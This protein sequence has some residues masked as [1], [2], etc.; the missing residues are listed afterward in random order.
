MLR[1]PHL[2]RV[3]RAVFGWAALLAAIA[4]AAEPVPFA[5]TDAV[6]GDWSDATKWTSADSSAPVAT[7]LA[8]YELDFSPAG[9]Y[10]ANQDL[11]AGF[12]LNRL[13]F[14]GSTVTLS[15]NALQFVTNGASLP[16]IRQN[17]DAEV[18]LD[19]PLGLGVDLSFGGT[20]TATV[21]LNGALTGNGGL[22]K[23]GPALLSLTAANSY[24]G[25]TT[26]TEGILRLA[27]PNTGND[28]SVVSIA[29]GAALDLT[30]TGSD[31][32]ASLLLAGVS[33]PDGLYDAANSGGAITG[34]GSLLVV[35]PP[36]WSDARL[37]SLAISG[38]SLSPSFSPL[39]GSYS[40]SVPNTVSTITVTPTVSG[41]G[42]TVTVN[43]NSV[44]PGAASNPIALGVGPNLITTQV[45][46]FDG[47]TT[48]TYTVNVSRGSAAVVGTSPA[49]VID[50]SRATLN[51]TTT[52]HGAA[53]VYFE[54]GPTA[55]FGS[56][57]P[58]RDVSGAGG[59]AAGVSGLS[60]ATTYHFRSVLVNPA[61][62]IYGETRQFTT[63]PN[64][65]VAA[66]GAPA[67]VTASTATLVGAVNPNGVQ[68]SVYFEYGLTT[69]YGQSTPVQKI[70]AGFATVGV[71]A[72]NLS[73]IA[74]GAYHYRLVASNSAGTALGNDV[75][76]S[77]TVGGGSG[78]GAPTAPPVVTT[79]DAAGIST[80]TA[81]LRGTVNPN[82]GTTLVKFEYGL[83]DSLGTATTLQG[84]GN[85]DDAADVAIPVQG[86][87]PGSTYHY[88]VSASNGLGTTPGDILTF[89]TDS[90]PPT[91]V[92]G[93]S[94][95]LTTTSVRIDGSARARGALA[96]VWIDYGTDGVSFDSV[97]ATPVS[98]SGDQ[99]TPVSAEVDEL[100]QGVTYYYRVRAV[101]PGGEGVGEI[102]TFNV[103]SLS[104]L[105]Q[106]YPPA[107]PLADRRGTVA[108]TLSP[109]DIGSGWR[110][111]GEQFWRES[112][113][114][115]TG[116]TAGD[117]V[118]EYRPV[119]GYVQPATEA[120]AVASSVTPLALT[121][122]YTPA[123]VTV[124]GSLTVILKPQDLTEGE[125]PAR[126]RFFGEE[127]AD[128]RESGVTVSDLAPGSYVIH[129][130]PIAGRA[131]PAPVTA[132]VDE[133][134]TTTL[135]I[136]YFIAEDPIGT[137]ATMVPFETFSTDTALPNA[138]VGQ[139]RSDAGLGSGFVVRPRV[140][141]TVGHAVFNDGTLSIATGLQWLFQHDRGV[142]DPVPKVPRGHYLM[143]GY[144]AQRVLDN[145]PGV[146]SPASQNLDVATMF[147]LEEVGR[148]GFS[149][150]LASDNL[151]NGFLL[152]NSL[153]TLVGYPIDGIAEADLDRL[154][155]TPATDVAFAPAFGRTF[156]TS[157]IRASGGASGGPVCVLSENGAYYPAAVYLGGTGQTVVRAFDSDVVE[158]IGFAN[159]SAG[160]GVGTSGGSQTG[161]TTEPY[162]EE[163]LGGLKVIIEP[164][165][166]RDAGAGWRTNAASP[167][168]PSGAQLDDLAPDLYNISF[169]TIAGFLP[170][171]M[172][173]VTL[174][175]GLLT[176]LTFTYESVVTAPVITSLGT[177]TGSKGEELSHQIT[178]DN[179]PVLFT[180]RGVLPDGMTFEPLSG[181]ISGTPLEA[182][183]F[184]LTIGASNSGGADS[185]ALV[186]T[187]LPGIA[188][189]AAT[190]PYLVPMSYAIVSSE[191][192]GGTQWAAADLPQFLSINPATGVISGTPTTPGVYSIPLTVTTLGAS[193]NATLTLTVTGTPPVITQHPVASR[194]LQ[195]G[196]TTTLI[197]AATG[198]PEPEFQ[199]YEGPS[200]NTDAPVLGA[201]SPTFTTP[202]LTGNTRFWARASSISG[203]ADSSATVITILPSSNANLIGLF[204]SQGIVTPAF[205]FGVTAY[206]VTVPNDVPAIQ[207]T[208]LV[209]VAQSTVKVAGHLVPTD[210]ASD[211]VNLS[212]GN[213][214]IPIDVTS[215]NGSVT[216]RYTLTV[217]RSQPPT[218]VSGTV[219]NAA[220]STATLRG[221]ATPNGP[222]TVFFQYGTTPAFGNATAGQVISGNAAQAITA[223]IFGLQPQVT[224]HFRIGITT[225]AGTI[226]GATNTFTTTQAPPLFA[227]GQAIDVDTDTGSVKLVGAVDP[228]GTATSVFFE[229]GKFDGPSWVP[230]TT[231]VQQVPGGSAVVD[232][233][234]T[235]TGL[236]VGGLYSYRLI[237][238]SSFGSSYGEFVYF[239]VGE[240]GSGTGIPTAAPVV[241]TLDALDITDS[242]A[243]LLGTVNPQGGTTFVRFEYG[244][245]STYGS[246]TPARGIGSGTEG[247][248]VA[249]E[250]SGLLPGQTYHYRVVA[251]NSVGISFGEDLT[252]V[253]GLQSPLATTGAAMPLE[254]SGIGVAGTVRARGGPADVFFE[255]GT[256]GISFP[257]RIR[258]TQITVNGDSNV[259]VSVSLDDLLPQTTYHYR[260]I[261][262]RT[263]DP[264]SVGVGETKTFR[265]DA[266]AGLFQKF[267]REIDA[268]AHAGELQ[269]NLIPLGTGKWRFVGEIDW[270]ASG[271]IA[272]GLATGDR[273]IEFF[274]VPGCLQPGRELVGLISGTPRLVLTREYFQTTTPQSGAIQVFLEPASRTGTTVPLSQRAQWRLLGFNGGPWYESGHALTGI[275]PGNHLVE[276]KAALD[277]D[278]PPPAKVLITD[279][280]TSTFAFAYNPDLDVPSS[281]LRELPFSDISTRRNLA[282]AYVGQF[283]TD[284]GSFSGFV[285][286][287]RVVATVAQ[288]LF[289][290]VTLA[291]VPGAQWLFQRS[292]EIH[293]PAPM[294]PR[295]FYAF[296]GYAAQRE[297]DN[298]PGQPSLESQKLDVAALYFLGEAGRGGYSGFLAT[299]ATTSP[300][301]DATTLKTVVGY[302]VRGGGST[303]GRGKMN[304]SRAKAAAYVPVSGGVFSTLQIYGL[305]GMLGGPVCAQRD[306]GSYFPAGIYLGGNNT[307]NHVRAID[308]G[309]IDLFGRAEITANTGDNNTSGGISLTSYTA[310]STTTNRGALTVILEPA[311][312]RLA[313]ALWKLGTD[314]SFVISSARKNNLTAGNYALEFKALPGFVAPPQQTVAVLANN[315]LTVT[316]TYQPA[317]SALALWRTTNFGSST[318]AGTGSD[319]QDPDGDGIINI[320]EYTAGTDPNDPTDVFRVSAA[321]KTDTTFSVVVPGKL[322]RLYTLERCAD[323][324][325]GL[326]Q[327]VATSGPALLNGD[328]NLTD[329]ALSGD[330]AFYRVTV[331]LLLP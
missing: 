89:T 160:D 29:A 172:Q 256:D 21:T 38:A 37:S 190:V 271:A 50:S 92:T 310:V 301:A 313:G 283:R 138:F 47:I 268:T 171:V 88:R 323:P 18:V 117:R 236:D 263:S 118:I 287:P 123:G 61:G 28:K 180:L 166:A 12:L 114:P 229:Y 70:P 74:N 111:A 312:A 130:K 265:S 145:S 285:V 232:I 110:F 68:A 309:V 107:V 277:L 205:N 65:P 211:P 331:E 280:Q 275:A 15:G 5:W 246:S 272:K 248:S 149:G 262:I 4:P 156:T 146:S 105:I 76:F 296:T 252:F 230:E 77:V 35:T 169:P 292:L 162:E 87:L 189:Q 108:L 144:A 1:F 243:L 13:T 132:T 26:V 314:S 19:T 194:S 96:E 80:E 57:T 324:A 217:G 195:F 238:S 200:G 64:P 106:Q 98:V 188:D 328:I 241:T 305:N 155:A 104:G 249:R 122:T 36:T 78:T 274:P 30:F 55:G 244:L 307:E 193:S 32:V 196:T 259:P 31:T 227:T 212:V 239:V 222:A 95:V 206:F 6:A 319:S 153:K 25:N 294:T 151:T 48:R 34:T 158:L 303:D 147:F 139:I 163:F 299:D 60:G 235:V 293:E 109:P 273:E 209:E 289:D 82:G 267:P 72:P 330:R 58:D 304:A 23:G 208:P 250:V 237:G 290:E 167:Y 8:T 223:P 192:G 242:T 266:L 215:G 134:Q 71:Q 183:V 213:T 204:T 84:I 42:A 44:T 179:S 316:V 261:A 150:Y 178:A 170:P 325:A 66:T 315:L 251:F 320:D 269:V 260:V 17:G 154:H 282:Y 136:T 33:K 152:S 143:T 329:P 302:P 221:T 157:D 254:V 228:N 20:G 278:A 281:S 257:D 245:T 124:G 207:I 165:A 83:T 45:R 270:R 103:E 264:N 120:V 86:L 295:G 40:T 9:T 133:G 141:A 291:Q 161:T 276:F 7:G 173:P 255:Y 187:S 220:D 62:T 318:N 63:A 128:W 174:E 94:T 127:E 231:P 11:N 81:I 214:V 41:E 129:C 191:S 311:E 258:A 176:T 53:T 79:V 69:A 322:G 49:V 253:T 159:D 234:A 175:A 216:K 14:G 181:L 52:P 22:T 67:N 93:D 2:T 126:W 321:T 286:K 142:H 219:T 148:G 298:T 317:V 113:A 164:A 210:A 112:G 137:P 73:L 297:V 226:F 99:V 185:K 116:L 27:Q 182:G 10:A 135:N 131:T 43:G 327:D 97:Q 3:F 224:Y 125:A 240:S 168:L 177:V 75:I 90:P 201:T 233:D 51:G 308:D 184:E 326:W 197:V 16:E 101:G 218:V 39:T 102:K 288:A 54:Y 24:R 186:L 121:R 115:A 85:G 284:S 59:F 202:P 279:G 100:D 56:R 198:L 119:A 225:G 247:A 199:W 140:V 300:L 306:G 203:S 91:A 46:A